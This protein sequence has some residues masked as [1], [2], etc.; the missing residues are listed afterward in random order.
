MNS[1]SQ[2]PSPPACRLRQAAGLSRAPLSHAQSKLKL[3][4]WDGIATLLADL[5]QDA[6][7]APLHSLFGLNLQSEEGH[8]IHA[9]IVGVPATRSSN[10]ATNAMSGGGSLPGAPYPLEGRHGQN[11][12]SDVNGHVNTDDV[13]CASTQA[14]SGTPP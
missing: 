3:G 4:L 10:L 1:N 14:V 7:S 6:A 9:H 5:E 8:A 12:H 2:H 11:G 13:G